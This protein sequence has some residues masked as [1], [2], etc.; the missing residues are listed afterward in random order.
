MLTDE[1]P[2]SD[3]LR[4]MCASM[5]FYFFELVSVHTNPTVSGMRQKVGVVLSF[6]DEWMA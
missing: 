4:H 5:G 2:C 1:P 6:E 3:C